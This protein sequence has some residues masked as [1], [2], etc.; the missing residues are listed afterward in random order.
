MAEK[1]VMSVKGSESKQQLI[2]LT[3]PLLKTYLW[4]QTVWYHFCIVLTRIEQSNQRIHAL[5]ILLS[6]AHTLESLTSMR[7]Q[8]TVVKSFELFPFRLQSS[9]LHQSPNSPDVHCLGNKCEQTA[10]F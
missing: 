10:N 1:P 5:R 6:L 9:I 3:K 4:R 8:Q 2:A 7:A